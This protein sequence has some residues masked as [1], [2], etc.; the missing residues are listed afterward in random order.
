MADIT[1][2]VA[3]PFV[4]ADDG[5]APGEATECQSSHAA[6][7]KAE[8]L[9]RVEGNVGAVAFSRTGDLSL[10]DFSDAVMLKA[11]GAVPNDLSEL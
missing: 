7:R 6:I 8:Q 4:A 11:F 10:G 3:L 2:Y 1:Y 9:S 5:V